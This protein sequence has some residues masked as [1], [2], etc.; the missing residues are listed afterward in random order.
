MRI[1]RNIGQVS[2]VGCTYDWHNRRSGR[3]LILFIPR[4]IAHVHLAADLTTLGVREAHPFKIEV[5]LKLV[6]YQKELNT[7]EII[8]VE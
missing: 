1:A 4:P 6:M 8:P 2:H 7:F 5:R 3:K